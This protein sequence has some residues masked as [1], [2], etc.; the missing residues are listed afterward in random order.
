[1]LRQVDVVVAVD[2]ENLFDHV[3][4]SCD[5]DHIG[6]RGDLGPTLSPLDE[7]VGEGCKYL[8]NRVVSDL[9]A[10]EPFDAVV[11]K[12]DDL[13]LDLLRI[14]LLDSSDNLSAGHFLNQQ[15]GA[16]GGIFIDSRIG[17]SLVAE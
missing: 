9:L 17:S 8:L 15:C 7:L 1:M 3:T 11:V 12:V 16:L 10:D 13:L 4:L 2:S 6:R 5:I 14:K